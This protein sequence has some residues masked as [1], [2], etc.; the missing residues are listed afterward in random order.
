MGKK[1]VVYYLFT[2]F[3]ILCHV[4]TNVCLC[5]CTHTH[6]HKIKKMYVIC[7]YTQENQGIGKIKVGRQGK[8]KDKVILKKR[9]SG[10]ERKCD[11]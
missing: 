6:T 9:K 2:C 7:V 5:I 8:V 4:I 11:L 1:A 10:K 3:F